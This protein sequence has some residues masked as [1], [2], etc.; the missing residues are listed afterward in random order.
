M[1]E[2]DI[3]AG[4]QVPGGDVKQGLEAIAVALAPH[5]LPTVLLQEDAPGDTLCSD[6]L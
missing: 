5:L 6:W 1:A 3:M 2:I 4:L